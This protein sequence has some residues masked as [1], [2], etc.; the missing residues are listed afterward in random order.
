MRLTNCE[1][2]CD[3][4]KDGESVHNIL[5]D[6]IELIQKRV[7]GADESLLDALHILY[8]N[9]AVAYLGLHLG[10]I[11]EAS[12]TVLFLHELTNHVRMDELASVS[13]GTG[14]ILVE[15]LAKLRLVS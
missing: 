7:G 1:A 8:K 12:V 2:I 10:K 6:Q 3:R 9:L 4:L 14:T 5:V 11:L 15:L 13:V